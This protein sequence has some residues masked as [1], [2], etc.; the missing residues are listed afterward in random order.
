VGISGWRLDRERQ[1][2]ALIFARVGGSLQY[3]SAEIYAAS[4]SDG[5]SALQNQERLPARFLGLNPMP[6]MADCR[7]EEFHVANGF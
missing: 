3:E 4:P 1:R 5:S 6:A 2:P 7:F